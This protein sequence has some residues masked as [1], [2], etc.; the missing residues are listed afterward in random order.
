MTPFYPILKIIH[1]T[2]V[3]ITGSLFTLRFVWM[4]QGTLQQR[5]RWVDTVPHV[6]DT[7][8]FVSGLMIASIIGQLPLQ[9]SWLTAKLFILLAYIVLGSIALKR[10]K[11]TQIRLWSGYAAIAC[12]LLI[13]SIALTRNPVPD[14]GVLMQRL[15]F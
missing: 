11:S 15:G 4:S 2:T 10:G 12:Y 9:A 7:L 6:N 13:I 14:I 5:G 3:V 1:V 8:L